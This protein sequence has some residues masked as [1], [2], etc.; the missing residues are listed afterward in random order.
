[1]IKIRYE[2]VIMETKKK[3]VSLLEVIN[4]LIFVLNFM[5]AFMFMLMGSA[6]DIG[7]GVANFFFALAYILWATLIWALIN[8]IDQYCNKRI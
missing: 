7:T 4:N 6:F 2:R 5:G 8:T 1:M 3:K